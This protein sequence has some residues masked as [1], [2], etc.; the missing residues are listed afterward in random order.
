MRDGVLT[1]SFENC[2]GDKLIGHLEWSDES[3]DTTLVGELGDAEDSAS[4]M[5]VGFAYIGD[6]ELIEIEG[7]N[8]VSCP[9]PVAK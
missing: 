8:L 9:V 1:F 2:D 4:L 5:P 6:D 3:E 7:L